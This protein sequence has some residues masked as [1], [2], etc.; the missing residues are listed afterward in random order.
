MTFKKEYALQ[1]REKKLFF[2]GVVK[3]TDGLRYWP[4]DPDPHPEPYQNVMDP[5]HC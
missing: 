2:V 4:E 3:I 5:E 1:H